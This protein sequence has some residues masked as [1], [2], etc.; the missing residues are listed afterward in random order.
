M[1]LYD[2]NS[3]FLGIGKEELSVLGFEDIDQFRES[4][5]DVAELFVNKAGY[6]YKFKNFS[7]IDYTLN[8][9][10]PK[11]SVILQ[12]RNGNEIE[13]GIKIKEIFALD[14]DD[15]Q[16]NY[17]SVEFTNASMQEN[18]PKQ[19]NFNA[20]KDDL[21]IQTSAEPLEAKEEPSTLIEDFEEHDEI[22]PS[23]DFDKQEPEEKFII[24]PSE[25]ELKLKVSSEVIDNSLNLAE[26][27]YDDAIELKQDDEEEIFKIK[28][29]P[30]ESHNPQ[31]RNTSVVK[32]PFDIVAC[33]E[34]LGLDF[35]LVAEVLSD[36]ERSID[37]ALPQIKFCIDTA[38][39]TQLESTIFK[40][41]GISDNLHIQHLSDQLIKI[42]KAPD[43]EA[44]SEEFENF[45]IMVEHF[46]EDLI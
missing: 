7:W 45:K 11:K 28:T 42:L 16:K 27:Y 46:K 34:T 17:Y 1:I 13:T 41:K 35:S 12:Q 21:A 33:A 22:P 40:L 20:P 6:I 32:I 2:K 43:A 24:K 23:I 36:Y 19:E 26:D 5:S 39:D 37:K 8:S 4:C 9:G 10:A 14:A 18:S 15:R 25:P 38:D 29:P 44:K 31:S 30:K 3:K